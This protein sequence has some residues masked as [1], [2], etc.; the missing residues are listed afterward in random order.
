MKKL[1]LGC[2]IILLFTHC[3]T[4]TAPTQSNQQTQQHQCPPDLDE[5]GIAVLYQFA[6]IFGNFI[7]VC[8]GSNVGNN[9]G[10]MVHGLANILQIAT[11]CGKNLE[12]Y[13]RSDAFKK[14]VTLLLKSKGYCIE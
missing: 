2:T 4:K 10:N 9:I 3:S 12:E 8:N 6:G 11:R 13:V 1:I 5:E 14:E 7:N